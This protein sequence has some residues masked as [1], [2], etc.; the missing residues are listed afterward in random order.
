MLN[1]QKF[2]RIKARQRGAAAVEF[3]IIAIVFFTLLFGIIEFGRLFYLYNT[4][5]E[6]TRCAARAAA[7]TWKGDN[8]GD[9]SGTN[10][11]G[12]TT[13][14]RQQCLFGQNELVAGWEIGT[15]DI[16][17]RA[18]NKCGND[19]DANPN[20]KSMNISNCTN[21]P[22]DDDCIRFV[23]ASVWCDQDS[24]YCQNHMVK[25]Q[26]MFGLI[27]VSGIGIPNSTVCMPA[28]S[29]GY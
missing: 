29:L 24:E 4:V 15:A 23:E 10:M 9:W 13:P 18:L 21:N 25:Y 12:T 6:V 19:D 16:R 20:D 11:I 8:G 5:Q 27:P 17:I 2:P 3:G 14:I 26:P 22:E 7:V 1:S 28:E